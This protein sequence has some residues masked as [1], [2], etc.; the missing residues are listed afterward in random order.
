MTRRIENHKRFT[1]STDTVL[2]DLK[3]DMRSLSE[4]K[5]NP[6][7]TRTHD[8]SQVNKLAEAILKFGFTVPIL[9]D[10]AEMII[11]GHG[12]AAAAKVLGLSQVPTIRLTHLTKA[13]KRAYVIADN[14]LAEL[15]GWDRSLLA[16]EFRDLGDL[17]F[18]V[19]LTGFEIRDIGLIIDEQGGVTEDTA[20]PTPDPQ[21]CVSRLGDLWLLGNHRLY[22]GSALEAASYAAL[23]GDEKAAMVFTDM[24]YNVPIR[25][26]VSGLGSARHR[27][28]AMA[29]G[30]MCVEQF[31][32]FLRTA[33]EHMA[34][35]SAD[36]SLHYLCMDWR[37]MG[38]VLSA[39]QGPY[40]ELK[41]LV[42][43]NKDNGGM[44]SLYRSKHELVFVYKKGKAPHVNNVEL[45]KNGRNRTNV[46]DYPGQNTFHAKRRGDL[47][48]HPTIKPTAL[49]ADA[50]RDVTRRGA[51]V[52]DPFVGSGTTILAAEATG[53]CARAIELDPVYVDVAIKRFE[54]STGQV[55]RHAA[56]GRTFAETRLDREKEIAHV[57]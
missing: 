35:W 45:G 20:V 55:A 54:S 8:R 42:V 38:E 39:A 3:V 11:A 47:A 50:I 1:I 48:D 12:R 6:R 56:T 4:L 43:W 18:D 37:H 53:R 49:V 21:N 22:C 13:E 28:F 19:S 26:H 32:G 16:Q 14:R 34:A 33:F 15:A 24:P 41:N 36:G 29:S 51:I 27:E 5:S 17:D 10:E 23:M 31:T 25:G 46:W 57:A 52:L 30:E 44:G 7:N 9:I 40:S 2:C